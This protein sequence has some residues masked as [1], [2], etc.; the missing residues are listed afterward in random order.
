MVLSPFDCATR[1]VVEGIKR[2][3]NNKRKLMSFVFIARYI[4][5]QNDG[6]RTKYT[7]KSIV[8]YLN[9]LKKL[10]KEVKDSQDYKNNF[11]RL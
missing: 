3:R 7:E 2:N 4:V 9:R 6:F 10:K 8:V 11:H 5:E 1:S